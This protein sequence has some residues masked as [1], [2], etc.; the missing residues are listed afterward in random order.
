V[1]V[2]PSTCLHNPFYPIAFWICNEQLAQL[3]LLSPSLGT[4]RFVEL[5]MKLSDRLATV[6]INV[7]G[8]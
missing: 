2:L 6:G 8:S 5:E 3:L 4:A 1:T 7:W